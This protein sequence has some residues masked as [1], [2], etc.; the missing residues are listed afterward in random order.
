M[1]LKYF[2]DRCGCDIENENVWENE[3]NRLIKIQSNTLGFAHNMH[4]CDDCYTGALT[5]LLSDTHC[6]LHPIVAKKFADKTNKKKK[7]KK[8]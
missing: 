1:G 5:Y 3:S 7:G 8:K 4:L 6:S 2:C